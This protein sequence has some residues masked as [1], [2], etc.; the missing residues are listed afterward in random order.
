MFWLLAP[1][2]LSATV[3]R[4]TQAAPPFVLYPGVDDAGAS[5]G[6]GDTAFIKSL[7]TA[8]DAAAC[9]S[10]CDAWRN[11]SDPARRCE[12]FT[13]YGP[14]RGPLQHQLGRGQQQ[15]QLQLQ[16]QRA[17]G[18]C[19]CFAHVSSAFFPN[20]SPSAT[21]GRMLP[22]SSSSS[23]NGYTTS[24]SS[25]SLE[26]SLNGHCEPVS[27]GG[28]GGSG[29]C[30]CERG[31]KGLRCGELDLGSV[32]RSR[33]GFVPATGDSSW[34]GGVTKAS[35]G[36]YHLFAATMSHR[37]GINAWWTNSQTT[38]AVSASPFGPYHATSAQPAWAAFSTG[39][40]VTRGPQGELVVTLTNGDANGSASTR[41]Y[42]NCTD[43]STPP[44]HPPRPQF[45][46]NM[47]VASSKDVAAENQS[48]T[49]SNVLGHRGWGLGI[50]VAVRANGSAVA[51]TRLGF[52]SSSDWR[53]RSAWNNP[54]SD[55]IPVSEANVEDGFVW[56]AHDGS[57]HALYHAF[58]PNFPGSHAFSVDGVAWHYG[59]AAYSNLVNFSDGSVGVLKRRERPHLIWSEDEGSRT[60]VIIG[61]LNGAVLTGDEGTY[62][63]KSFTLVTPVKSDDISLLPPPGP[64]LVTAKSDDGR[65]SC[66][67][68]GVPVAGGC[69][70]DAAWQGATCTELA[71]LPSLAATLGT[72]YPGRNSWHSHQGR[73]W[74]LSL[75]GE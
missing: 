44:Y 53:N 62:G 5:R 9:G 69:R 26:C 51:V 1:L 57:F 60:G 10:L 61:L 18:R 2:V 47:A 66:N 14:Q 31:W 20:P 59:G 16:Q 64:Q 4:G 45:Y 11:A 63:D 42:T 73:R 34:G 33:L 68:H 55:S 27:A 46:T 67:R 35:D 74:P 3:V 15:Q 56:Q 49:M 71:L 13:W 28:S 50:S 30:S 23:S 21:S 38:H 8:A 32:N 52:V 25:P 22:C 29:R 72:I 48:W 70:C 41:P 40:G 43:G 6:G 19:A 17:P 39:S 36:S 65:R 7:G 37:C 75:A 24:G 12:A 54:L 58:D